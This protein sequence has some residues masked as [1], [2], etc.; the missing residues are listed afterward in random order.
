[1]HRKL[2]KKRFN[3]AIQY[4]SVFVVSIFFILPFYFTVV[5]SVRG[6]MDV[7]VLGLP[8]VIHLDNFVQAIVRI[9][10]WQYLRSSVII[11]SIS[12]TLGV[13][14]NF[15]LGYSFARMNAPLKDLWFGILISLMM[16][17]DVASTIPQYVLFSNFHI[18]NTYWIWVLTGLGGSPYYTFLF[19]QFM[20]G[21]PRELEEAARI[22]GCS[23]IQIITRIFVPISKPVI[24]VVFMF[25]FL[26]S[27]GD[28]N[29]PFMYLDQ[30]KWPL[31]S[32]LMGINYTLPN[33]PEIVLQ[34]LQLAFGILFMIPSCIVYF[35][36]QKHLKDGMITSGLKG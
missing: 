22:D 34:P 12:I 35:L 31:S 36:G 30:S 16:I 17:P 20:Q 6:V 10:F 3:K 25:I 27:W 7:P 33:R 2:I 5:N 1:M 19:R 11:L 23:T 29:L 13:S 32:A 28:V 26:H 15:L 8:E 18:A 21:V 4:I 9:P 24:A 14:I